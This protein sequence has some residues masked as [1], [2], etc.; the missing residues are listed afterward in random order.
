MLP[1]ACVDGNE[2]MLVTTPQVSRYE[3][4]RAITDGRDTEPT[5][6]K[7]K[8]CR[9]QLKDECRHDQSVFIKSVQAIHVHNKLTSSP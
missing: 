9:N 3:C 4:V 6:S 2:F 5:K 7:L 1:S 8:Y